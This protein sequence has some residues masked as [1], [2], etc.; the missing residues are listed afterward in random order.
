MIRSYQEERRLAAERAAPAPCP[1]ATVTGVHPDGLSLRFDGEEAA[2]VR[3]YPCNAA[4]SFAVG[5][6]VRLEKAGGSYIAAY[7]VKGGG[8]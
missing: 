1:F 6:R 5:Q 8:A 7:P 4:V 2:R 3:H